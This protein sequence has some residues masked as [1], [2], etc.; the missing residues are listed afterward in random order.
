MTLG[1]IWKEGLRP[2]ADSVE[3]EEE[4][5]IFVFLCLFNSTFRDKA[6]V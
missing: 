4:V 2:Q 5:A 6:I 3:P 1:P